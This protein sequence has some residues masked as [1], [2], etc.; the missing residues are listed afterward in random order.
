M[1]TDGQKITHAPTTFVTGKICGPNS[2]TLR[3]RPANRSAFAKAIALARF[4][5]RMAGVEP[6]VTRTFS[7]L[8]DPATTLVEVLRQTP[9]LTGTKDGCDRGAC[10]A[11]TVWLEGEVAASC[12]SF[13]L[14]AR[15]RKVTTVEGLTDGEKLHPVQQAFIKHGAMQCEFCTPE[16]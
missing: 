7:L 16:M 9:V 2:Q 1:A 6:D 10:P 15:G 8:V 14:D 5:Q 3:F 4:L 11:G 12:M 13:A